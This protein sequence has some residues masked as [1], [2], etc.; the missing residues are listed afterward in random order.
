MRLLR[1]KCC[2]LLPLL[3]LVLVD[4]IAAAGTA[5]AAIGAAES[6]CWHVL[7][8]E[9][10]LLYFLLPLLTRTATTFSPRSIDKLGREPSGTALGGSSAPSGSA[11]AAA[12]GSR[13][14]APGLTRAFAKVAGPTKT[15][16][17]FS[18]ELSSAS[19]PDG[20]ASPEDGADTASAGDT[21]LAW[22][23]G[24]LAGQEAAALAAQ[25][26]AAGSCAAAA[27]QLCECTVAGGFYW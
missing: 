3:L 23:A 1:C 10:C 9:A 14:V 6:N 13:D 21:E 5:A 4:L 25:V 17:S 8:Q 16:S 7:A 22:E 19:G 24:F 20:D 26:R 2:W 27:V 18:S 11:A 12:S 15:P